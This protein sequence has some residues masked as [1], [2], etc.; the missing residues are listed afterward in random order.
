MAIKTSFSR[1]AKFEASTASPNFFNVLSI[2]VSPSQHKEIGPRLT[3]GGVGNA[4]RVREQTQFADDPPRVFCVAV[5][6]AVA[7]R[8]AELAFGNVRNRGFARSAN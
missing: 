8:F 5:W 3:L 1:H 4:G 6:G 2:F 7:A